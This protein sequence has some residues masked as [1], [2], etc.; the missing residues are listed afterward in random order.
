MYGVQY[1]YEILDVSHIGKG[2]QVGQAS[3]MK[4]PSEEYEQQ[5]HDNDKSPTTNNTNNTNT[6]NKEEQPPMQQETHQP[7]QPPKQGK[8]QEQTPKAVID[9]DDGVP[10]DNHPHGQHIGQRIGQH[11]LHSKM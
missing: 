2:G 11:K 1:A 10:L 9:A 3:K 8:E 5:Q 4:P 7:E 6:N